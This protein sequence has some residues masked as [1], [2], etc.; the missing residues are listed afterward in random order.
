MG[1]L[2][3][4]EKAKY[5]MAHGHVFEYACDTEGCGKLIQPGELYVVLKWKKRTDGLERMLGRI[6]SK[7]RCMD[8]ERF[9]HPPPDV[10]KV[11][12]A[13][14]LAKKV[15]AEVAAGIQIDQK[16]RRIITKLLKDNPDGVPVKQLI[17]KLKTKK[18]VREMSAKLVR[19]TI[20]GMKKLKLM[21]RSKGNFMLPK[22]KKQRKSQKAK[23]VK[24]T[25]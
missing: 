9:I 4:K 5:F 15:S 16:L 12:N 6:P 20:K 24:V 21:R 7:I 10:V 11:K 1:Q 19:A 3:D 23:K 8:C 18:V 25:K 22:E 2:T 13:G 17:V 14:R